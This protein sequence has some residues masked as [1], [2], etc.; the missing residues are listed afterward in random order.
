MRCFV[1]GRQAKNNNLASRSSD[2]TT[3][4]MQLN[5]SHYFDLPKSDRKEIPEKFQ[6]VMQ[7]YVKL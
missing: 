5:P 4:F 2:I 6:E 7:S 1:V 3:G